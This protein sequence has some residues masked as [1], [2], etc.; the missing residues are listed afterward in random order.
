MAADETTVAT[1]EAGP[2]ETVKREVIEELGAPALLLPTLV[3]RGLKANDRA[4]YQLR[5]VCPVG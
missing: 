5:V 3:T 4:K 2:V 1:I